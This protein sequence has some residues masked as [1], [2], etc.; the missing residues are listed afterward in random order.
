MTTGR[1]MFDLDGSSN[2]VFVVSRP[3][4]V[5]RSRKKLFVAVAAALLTACSLCAYMV[6]SYR[7]SRRGSESLFSVRQISIYGLSGSN[8]DLVKESLSRFMGSSLLEISSEDIKENIS[9]FGFIDGC[10][11][12]KQ[13]PSGIAVE[14]KQKP[15]IGFVKAGAKW[16]ELDGEGDFWEAGTVPDSALQVPPSCDLGDMK[17]QLC[18][19]EIMG[20]SLAGAIT[21]VEPMQP[22]SFLL[23]TKEGRKLIVFAEDF[24]KQWQ[25]YIMSADWIEKNIGRNGRMDLRWSGRVVFS[26]F[27]A[28]KAQAEEAKDGKK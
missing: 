24:G 18:V 3:P 28:E 5:R 10:L 21:S 13:Y 22:D 17:F 26:P 8:A 27:E 12:R 15:S 19:K 9:R 11:L 7:S 20:A 6:V 25:K 4:S 1:Q 23:T 2:L 16:Y 14:I